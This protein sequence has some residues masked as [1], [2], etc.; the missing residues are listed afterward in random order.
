MV[1]IYY[2]KYFLSLASHS[3]AIHS[4]LLLLF[5]VLINY[6]GIIHNAC[7]EVASN[8]NPRRWVITGL[9]IRI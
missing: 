4:L 1:N 8:K 7:A 5:S 6:G 2:V 9:D 3:G